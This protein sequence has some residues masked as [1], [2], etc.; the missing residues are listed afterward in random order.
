MSSTTYARSRLDVLTAE[1]KALK[2]RLE[3]TERDN[4]ELKQSV[5]EL[6]ARLSAALAR[7]GNGN[8]YP[9]AHQ[10]GDVLPGGNFD[11]LAAQVS[12]LAADLASSGPRGGSSADGGEGASAA[13]A[14]GRQLA[15]SAT[16]SGHA[17][18]VY[19]VAF[20]PSGRLLASGS[21]DKSVRCWAIGEG[22]PRETLCLQKH[23]H[24][25]SSLSWSADARL[26]LSGSYDHTVR[27]WD[28]ETAQAMRLWHAP[29]GSFVQDVNFHPMSPDVF[30]AATTGHAL[31][32]FDARKPHD[33]PAAALANGTMVNAVCW[34][35]AGDHCV[36]GDKC[37][38]RRAR[39]ATRPPA[40]WLALHN[41]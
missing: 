40:L 8:G 32:L 17:G 30:A 37:V 23:A 13:P 22:E 10:P 28:V 38:A 11:E 3:A 19:T 25:V 1:N 34:L 39:T 36:S 35:P 31:L 41:A 6:S 14:D 27:M 15:P 18:A 4:R 33:K 24:N 20:A 29:D 16:L 26:L 2:K 7:N 5:Y 12:E 21:Y 9:A